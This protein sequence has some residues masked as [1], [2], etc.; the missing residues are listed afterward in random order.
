MSDA[1]PRISTEDRQ[2]RAITIVAGMVGAILVLWWVGSFGVNV[3]IADDWDHVATSVH[4]HDHGIDAAS[5]LIPHN[6]HCIA[7]PRLINHAFLRL[8]EGD[9]RGLLFMNAALGIGSLMI[10]LAVVCRRALPPAAFAVVAGAIAALM[11]GWCQWQNLIWA[12]QTPWFLLPLMLVAAAA[13]IARARS[14]RLA[15][16]VTAAAAILGPLCMANGILVGWALLPG[17]AFR[18]ADEPRNDAWR[19]LAVV[20]SVAVLATVCGLAVTARVRGPSLGGAAAAWASPAETSGL[21]LAML[22]SPLDPQGAFAGR[23]TVAALAGGVSLAVGTSAVAAALRTA[24]ARS[25]RELGPGF[26]LMLYG[27]ASVGAVVV[28]RLSQLATAPVESRYQSFAIMWHVGV[29]LTCSWLAT[30]Q[31]G[32]ARRAWRLVLV[33]AAAASIVTTLASMGLFNGHGANMRR[34]LEEH[35]A[36]YRAAREPDGRKQLE[37]ISRH[38]GADGILDRLE[39]MRR[40]GILHADYAPTTFRE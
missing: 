39:G 31:H 4:W 26:A 13:T 20:T 1:T 33:T 21:L 27:L 30:E 23:K 9:Y 2:R 15:V 3:P 37:G 28:G 40:A 6:E 11:S 25:G 35:Q 38:Y 32:S 10:V 29:I 7:I 24:R 17:L 22:G 14:L 19:H 5:L 12:F 36:I 8:F 16:A 18:L 34:A